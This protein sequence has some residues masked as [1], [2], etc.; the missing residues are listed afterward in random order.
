MI[1]RFFIVSLILLFFYSC[2]STSTQS[3]NTTKIC[4]N[5]QKETVNLKYYDNGQLEL[6]HIYEVCSGDKTLIKKIKYHEEG[7]N[8]KLFE[9]SYRGKIEHG[10]WIEYY[11]NG[12][13]K[14]ESNYNNG[15]EH[16]KWYEYYENGRK[17][18]LKEWQD[19]QRYG[20]W[21]WYSSNGMKE[22]EKTY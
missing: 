9:R 20:R 18:S 21:I 1:N 16:G 6:V 15:I 2:S 3:T 4:R 11:Q 17:K 10:A 14:S 8:N 19:G 22:K 12:Q 13:K 5:P 7:N